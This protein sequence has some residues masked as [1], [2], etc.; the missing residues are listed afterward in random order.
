MSHSS[1]EF[2]FAFCF[3]DRSDNSQ[4]TRVYDR[5]EKPRAPV[6]DAALTL[7]WAFGNHQ[8]VQAWPRSPDAFSLLQSPPAPR[9][10]DSVLI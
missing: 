4:N 3:N 2:E 6:A 5:H 9:A 7:T 1:A 8:H 10:P